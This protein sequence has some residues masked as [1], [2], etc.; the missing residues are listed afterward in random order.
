MCSHYESLRDPDRLEQYFGATGELPLVWNMYPSKQGM[1]IR[2]EDNC[3]D[4]HKVAALANNCLFS[5]SATF[6]L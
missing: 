2:G 6:W 4:K 1:F 5:L 3:D